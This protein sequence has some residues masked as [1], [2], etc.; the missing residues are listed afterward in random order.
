MTAINFYILSADKKLIPFVCQLVQT[1]L[2]KSTEGLII[3]T[4]KSLLDALDERLWSFHDT[5]FI[6]HS[7]VKDSQ[8]YRSQ[9]LM[10]VGVALTDNHDLLTDFDGVVLNL[11]SQPL[12]DFVANN[13]GTKLL[14]I[15]AGGETSLQ[16]GRLKYRHYREQ[17]SAHPLHTYTI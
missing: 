3:L 4:P 8:A 14:E 11:T 13:H 1:V 9:R 12:S 17:H 5:A 2:Q 10:T 15:I 6:P 16:H 7:V